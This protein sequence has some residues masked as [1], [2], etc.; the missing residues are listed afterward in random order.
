MKKSTEQRLKHE[1]DYILFLEKRLNS[2]HYKENT[3][4]E[5]YANTETK[6][7]KAK[8]IVKLLK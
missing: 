7:K 4:L 3:S 5:E 8:L 2:K 6:L 1:R